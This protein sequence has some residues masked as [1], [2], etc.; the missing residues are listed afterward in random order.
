MAEYTKAPIGHV[1]ELYN[2]GQK[3]LV[4]EARDVT[5]K[6]MMQYL[7]NLQNL[8]FLQIIWP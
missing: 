7:I 6:T 2:E 4:K 5:I 1:Q 3:P 8:L